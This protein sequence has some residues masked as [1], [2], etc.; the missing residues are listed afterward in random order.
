MKFLA[1]MTSF[2]E[3]A[4]NEKR[5]RSKIEFEDLMFNEHLE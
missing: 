1:E 5:T 2:R 4:Y 3:N